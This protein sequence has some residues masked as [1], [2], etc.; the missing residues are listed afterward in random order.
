MIDAHMRFEQDWDQMLLDMLG[1]CPSSNAVLTTFPTSYTPPDNCDRNGIKRMAFREFTA[2]SANTPPKLRYRSF[3]IS[4]DALP[5][6]PFPAASVAHGFMFASARLFQTVAIDP[7][8]YFFGDELTFAA[9]AWTHGWDFFSPHRPVVF[10]LWDRT[11]RPR[12][13]QDRPADARVLRKVSAERVAHLVGIRQSKDAR[14]LFELSRYGL[15]TARTLRDYQRFSGVNFA[16]RT[17][18]PH[19]LAG[20]FDTDFSDVRP[21]PVSK[22]TIRAVGGESASARIF[23]AIRSYRDPQT[24]WTIQN[25]FA[26]AAKPERISVGVCWQVEPSEDARCFTELYPYPERVRVV[27]TLASE[28]PGACWAQ[29]QALALAQ[30]EEYVLLIDSHMRFVQGWDESLLGLCDSTEDPKAVMTAWLPGYTPPDTLRTLPPGQVRQIA[31]KRFSV[32]GHPS[33]IHLKG[34]STPQE[35]V[36]AVNPTPFLVANFVFTRASAFE[37]VSIDPHI[38][39]YGE[40]VSLSARLWTHGYTLY[41]P[42][43]ALAYHYWKPRQVG[44]LD[45]YKRRSIPAVAANNERVRHL[46]NLTESASSAALVDNDRYRLG[47][48][49]T[50]ESLWQFAGVD[51]ATRFVSDGALNARWNTDWATQ[52]SAR[53]DR[54]QSVNHAEL[55]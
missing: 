41:E 43:I 34:V 26:T 12:H 3:R 53:V 48:V 33:I 39:L 29:A 18:A 46:L 15:G 7:Y 24:Q 44:L 23:V 36:K 6:A 11:T 47:T 54:P 1:Q 49:R 52:R 45:T 31:V 8:I 19:A 13:P 27:G 37:E 51:P 14:A 25:L 50:L 20:R 10:H 32:D 5:A 2:G 16:K 22:D 38:H 4:P 40:E 55:L 35:H 9:R 30:G 17:I 42:G 21:A 28:T